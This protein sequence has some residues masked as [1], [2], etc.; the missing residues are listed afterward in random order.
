LELDSLEVEMEL[1]EAELVEMLE[2]L[3]EDDSE[4]LELDE[5]ERLLLELLDS[6]SSCRPMT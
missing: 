1:E 4:E 6:P 2:V 3:M 5:L